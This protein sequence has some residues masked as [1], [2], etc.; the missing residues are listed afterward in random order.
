[1]MKNLAIF[2][3]LFFAPMI[4]LKIL[5]WRRSDVSPSAHER[6]STYG[7]FAVLNLFISQVVVDII[8]NI[9]KF[10]IQADMFQYGIIALVTAI[11][12]PFIAEV[13]ITA[14]R[15]G[16]VEL[17]IERKDA[18]TLPQASESAALPDT[19]D[20]TVGSDED[21]NNDKDVMTEVI[22]AEE[23]GGEVTQDSE[24]QTEEQD[25]EDAGN[26]EEQSETNT[27]EETDEEKAETQEDS[28]TEA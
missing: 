19:R 18:D 15:G 28:S 13:F 5:T 9:T 25:G 27:A 17:S 7:V 1:M 24:E 3:Y 12:L 26:N 22:A 2:I 10:T 4:S 11:L 21:T 23:K 20:Q 14:T 16:H 8:R 6:I